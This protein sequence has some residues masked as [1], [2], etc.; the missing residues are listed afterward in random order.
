ME[1]CYTLVCRYV[2]WIT[3]LY[4]NSNLC[5]NSTNKTNNTNPLL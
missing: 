2:I 1:N 4:M 5:T 3:H